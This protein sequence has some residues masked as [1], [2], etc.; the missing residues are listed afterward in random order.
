MTRPHERHDSRHR[1]R[2]AALQMLYQWEIGGASVDDVIES[3]W[4]EADRDLPS[5]SREF[6][7]TLMR[8]VVTHH[9][10]ID[11]L[12]ADAAEH[13]RLERMAV[14]DRLIMRLAVEELVHHPHTPA[15]VVIDEALELTRTFST[16]DA[17]KFVNGNLDAIRRRLPNGVNPVEV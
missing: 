6:A 11:P 13:W 15:S 16:E 7:D 2:E 17:V 4:S 12:I 5:A 3:Y 1:A 14:I 10:T 8:G 9:E